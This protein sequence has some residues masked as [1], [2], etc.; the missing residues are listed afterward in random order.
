M[1]N[2]EKRIEKLSENLSARERSLAVIDAI[3]R[4]DTNTAQSLITS[5]PMKSYSQRD[6]AITDFV[7]IIEIISLTFDRGYYAM[8]A[9]LL[10]INQSDSSDRHVRLHNM[11]HQ[12]RGFI[13]GLQ[14]FSERIDISI[15]RLLTFSIANDQ[16]SLNKRL[17]EREPI[18]GEDTILAEDICSII[19]ELWNNRAKLTMFSVASGS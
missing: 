17:Q 8:T 18:S 7:D 10:E 9:N 14:L 4:E 5:A 16:K 3:G 1:R 2:L 13:G 19:E 12:L 15:D 6:A 11:E